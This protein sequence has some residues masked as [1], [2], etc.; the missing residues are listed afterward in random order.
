MNY[1]TV[2]GL[3]AAFCT[4]VAFVPQAIKAW[5]TKSTH[6]MSLASFSIV[7]FG[8]AMWLVYGILIRDIPL[9]TAN[10]FTLLVQGANLYLILR[11]N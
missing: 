6:D 4:T 7:T 8:V 5:K 1:V 2:I 11:Y 10:V 9:I 3:V